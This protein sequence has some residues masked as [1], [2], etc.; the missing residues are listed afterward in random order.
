VFIMDATFS[1]RRRTSQLIA[2][3]FFAILVLP[4]F[5]IIGRALLLKA[6]GTTTTAV[7]LETAYRATSSRS[8]NSP[9]LVQYEFHLPGSKKFYRFWEPMLAGDPAVDVTERVWKAAK[10]T[11]TISVVYWP[12]DPWINLPEDHS[13]LDGIICPGVAAATMALIS[14]AYFLSYIRKRRAAKQAAAMRDA[15]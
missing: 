3:L 15:G 12:G 2:A 14:L 1:E 9:F 6:D 8:V 11:G 4:F 5:T 7:V 13:P 10:R